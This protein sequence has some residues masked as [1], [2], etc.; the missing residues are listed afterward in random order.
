MSGRSATFSDISQARAVLR[1]LREG[2]LPAYR[3]FHADLLFH[4]TEET[5]FGAFFVGRACEAILQQGAPWDE[6]E[7]IVQGALSR[8]NDYIGHRPGGGPG[9]TS[10]RTVSAR[11]AA[12]GAAVH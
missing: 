4:Q 8:L 1:L 5:L 10:T 3:T 11:V 7:R 12:S 9:D 2:V 6:T